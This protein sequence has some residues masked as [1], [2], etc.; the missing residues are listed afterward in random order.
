M[1]KVYEAPLT[2]IVFVD[3]TEMICTSITTAGSTGDN[4]ITTADGRLLDT[5]MFF[6]D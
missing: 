4:N 6:D 5:E 2:E 1:K 3:E